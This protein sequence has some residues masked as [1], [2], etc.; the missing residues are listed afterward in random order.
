MLAG[1]AGGKRHRR[2]LVLVQQPAAGLHVGKR[3]TGRAE[4]VGPV[5]GFRRRRVVLPLPDFQ[6]LV[7]FV[8]ELHLKQRLR[9]VLV[10]VGEVVE[11]VGHQRVLARSNDL[12][13]QGRSLRIL[14]LVHVH[15]GQQRL[16][17]AFGGA[18]S[19]GRAVIQGQ[20]RN[21]GLQVRD[22]QHLGFGLRALLH[23]G[24]H[25][26]LHRNQGH[27]AEEIGQV[28]IRQRPDELRLGQQLAF[29]PAVHLDARHVGQHLVGAENGAVIVVPG[30]RRDEEVVIRR[31]E[32]GEV[33]Q[34]HKRALAVGLIR[35]VGHEVPAAVVHRK[36]LQARVA[37]VHALHGVVRRFPEVRRGGTVGVGF[38]QQIFFAARGRR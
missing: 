14:A 6:P 19:F 28:E 2:V 36:L 32:T 24:V 37:G 21:G 3:G 10:R 12:G 29:Q 35:P 1:A 16:R 9:V 7:V 4:E 23:P 31:Q 27:V 30:E 20:V 17:G 18:A 34:L 26:R 25:L 11:V 33:G 15:A 13:E 8:G 38:I 5:V 22:N